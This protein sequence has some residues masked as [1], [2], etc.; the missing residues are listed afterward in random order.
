M[1]WSD[2]INLS[3]QLLFSCQ[4]VILCKVRRRRN[5]NQ[6]ALT[7]DQENPPEAD[8]EMPTTEQKK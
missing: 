5:R 3:T 8:E 1:A 4:A 2:V 6:D 7:G